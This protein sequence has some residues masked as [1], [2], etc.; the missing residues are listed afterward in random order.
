[1]PASL[2]DS[3]TAL[4]RE[5]LAFPKTLSRQFVYN[6]VG[7]LTGATA[8]ELFIDGITNKRLGLPPG[9]SVTLS[10]VLAGFNVTDS[11]NAG[12]SGVAGFFRT[13]AGNVTAGASQPAFAPAPTTGSTITAFTVTADT[14]NQAVI[15]TA[16]GTAA[17]TI[18]VHL[19]VTVAIAE[20]VRINQ[21]A[22]N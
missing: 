11:L 18:Y 14:T 22:I 6:Y 1:M 4:V 16:T 15:F 20:I 5:Q 10:Y 9:C 19:I 13:A 21:G 8:T 17:K 3:A 7:T 12:G 2:Q